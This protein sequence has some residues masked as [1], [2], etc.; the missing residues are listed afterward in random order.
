MRTLPLLVCVAALAATVRGA[1]FERL[2][3]FAG[4]PDGA[5][6]QGLTAGPNG[7]LYGTTAY[8]G[9]YG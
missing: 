3:Q 8:G 7:V 5:M 2:Y 6:P 4:S 1:G 9:A